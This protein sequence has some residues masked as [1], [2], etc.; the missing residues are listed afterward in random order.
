MAKL[1]ERKSETEQATEALSGQFDA[2]NIIAEHEN[3]KPESRSSAQKS[4]ETA[5]KKKER[6]DQ[7]VTFNLPI[8]D[9]DKYK[10]WFGSKGISMSMGLRMC[11]D[12]LYY[13]NKAE[14]I[15]VTK[16]GIREND[17]MRLR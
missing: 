8:E 5:Q 4:E 14:K 3:A 11:L 2:L 12:Y 13:Q 17:L 16:S 10:S 7:L 15:E 9:F 1:T 6:K